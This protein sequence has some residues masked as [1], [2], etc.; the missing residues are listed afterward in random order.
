MD[1]CPKCWWKSRTIWVNAL[2]AMVVAI[3]QVLPEIRAANTQLYLWLAVILPAA[4]IW[5]RFL[6]NQA[7]ANRLISSK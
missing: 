1:H 3:L 2:A 4:N 6:T 7:I 5:L